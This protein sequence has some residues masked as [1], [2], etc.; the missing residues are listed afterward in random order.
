MREEE[1]LVYHVSAASTE[2]IDCGHVA[3]YA[4]TSQDKLARAR[5]VLE[6][7]RIKLCREPIP[8]DEVERAQAW[9]VGQGDAALQR[10]GRVA[11]LLAFNEVYGLGHAAHFAYARRIEAVRPRDVTA[12]ANA[13]LR[14]DRLVTSI[15]AG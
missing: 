9:L 10:R 5:E 6:R 7:E 11:S 13:I 8:R 1:G 4:A 2:G 12:L 14:P 15:V 3:F